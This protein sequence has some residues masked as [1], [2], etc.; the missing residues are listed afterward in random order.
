MIIKNA[1]VF[2]DSGRFED[3]DIH[4][5]NEYIAG[6]TDSLDRDAI[7]A[8]GCYAIPGLVDLHLHGC[9]GHEFAGGTMADFREMARYQAANGVTTI[10][11]AT[12]T[13]AEDVLAE[14]CR[15]AADFT[16]G[17]G[18]D[19]AGIYLEGP[20]ISPQRMGAQNPAFIRPP[21]INMLRRLQAASGGTVKVLAIA[22]ELA[23]AME[24]IGE[25]SGEIV[26][27]IAHT[28]A[29]YDTAARA[30][31]AGASH[32]TH[33]YN[34]MPPFSHREPGVVGA[35]LDAANSTAELI[36]DGVHIHPSVARATFSM[37][38]DDRVVLVSDS[39]MAAG[40]SDG[41]YVLGKLPVTVRG[42]TAR[43]ANDGSIA[44]S[45]TNLMG[46][47]RVAVSMGIPLYSAVKC[48][49]VNPARVLGISDSRGSLAPGK[50]AD[51]VLLREDLSVERVIL[52]GKALR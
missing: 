7:D 10:C 2:R 36:C 38:G 30:F 37:F 11:P 52:R 46:C 33:L 35:A 25:V 34:A 8:A 40:L 23:G 27:S 17:D 32:V 42:S 47:V 6:D 28:T 24:L 5:E 18:A 39:M 45:V 50:Y 4:I 48:A 19:I 21:D 14:T 22:P 49:S 12:L 31:R 15:L 16:C 51:I 44:G 20:F 1:R 43:L 3:G 13:L 41:E 29:D 26:C 9:A